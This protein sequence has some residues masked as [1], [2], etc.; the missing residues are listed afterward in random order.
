MLMDFKFNYCAWVAKSSI[1]LCGNNNLMFQLVRRY[2][3]SGEDGG[4]EQKIVEAAKRAQNKIHN[5]TRT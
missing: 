3:A 2:S 4:S 5:V 1:Y